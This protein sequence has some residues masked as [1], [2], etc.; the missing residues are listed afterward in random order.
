MTNPVDLGPAVSRMCSIVSGVPSGSLG[1]PTPCAKY[2]VGDL[3]DHVGRFALAFHGSAVKE[4]LGR[5]PV[6]SAVD[7]PEDWQTKI[8]ADL[9]AMGAAW[10]EPSAWEGMTAL[11]EIEMPA[12]VCAMVGL[13]ELI[14]HGWDLAVATGQDASYDGTGLEQMYPVIAGFA[15]QGGEG[16][17]GPEVEVPEDAPLFDRLLGVAGR[18]PAWA[19]PGG[20]PAA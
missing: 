4:P 11:G 12:E 14:V 16:L 1:Q 7:L 10:A 17:F 5:A 2:A 9:Q 19:P 6:A 8:P 18:D 15:A 13:D 20:S 3:L